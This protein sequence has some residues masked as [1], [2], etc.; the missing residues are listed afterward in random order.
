MFYKTI[1]LH[2]MKCLVLVSLQLFFRIQ[3]LRLRDLFFSKS[4]I[5]MPPICF[6]PPSSLQGAQAKIQ[7]LYV[8]VSFSRPWS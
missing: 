3:S 8:I 1:Y 7:P 2:K 4:E 6:D 5:G